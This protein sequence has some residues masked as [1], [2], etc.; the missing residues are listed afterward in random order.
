MRRLL[1]V[2]LWDVVVCVEHLRVKLRHSEASDGELGARAKEVARVLCTDAHEFRRTFPEAGKHESAHR[3]FGLHLWYEVK[4]ES[5]EGAQVLVDRFLS[6]SNDSSVTHVAPSREEV[7]AELAS[8]D[9]LRGQQ[10]FEA[11]SL[12]EDFRPGKAEVVV[13][14]V[15]TGV[16]FS[17][18]DL[19]GSIW[20][21]PGEVPGNGKDDDHNG[22]VRPSVFPSNFSSGRRRARLELR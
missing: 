10:Q 6:L 1:V 2:V 9:V 16:D 14:I 19:N 11:I 22:Y 3:A 7:H 17:H 21:N 20:T 5:G 12:S 4:C 18:V 13:Q 8:D 15:D